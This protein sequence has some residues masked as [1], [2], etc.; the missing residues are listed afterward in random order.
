M[1]RYGFRVHTHVC[2]TNF[3]CWSLT[4]ICS[5]PR[6][7]TVSPYVAT[8]YR[9]SSTSRPAPSAGV[10]TPLPQSVQLPPVDRFIPC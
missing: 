7:L 8:T 2:L 9:R 5:A 4:L 1:H 3:S 6:L 10:Q